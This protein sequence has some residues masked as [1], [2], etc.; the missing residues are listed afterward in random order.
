VFGV[1]GRRWIG[2]DLSRSAVGA[3]S[4][5]WLETGEIGI[6]GL[7]RWIERLW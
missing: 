3:C 4:R 2:G 5:Y 7:W 1:C 6:V